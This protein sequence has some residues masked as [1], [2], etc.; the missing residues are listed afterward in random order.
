MPLYLLNMDGEAD[1][2][3]AIERRLKPAIQDLR[4]ISAIDDIGRASLKGATRSIAIAPAPSGEQAFA[5]LLG[6]VGDRKKD[7]F[8]IIIGGDL[9]ARDYK[10]L[11]QGGNAE[12]VIDSGSTEELLAIVRRI[13]TP[14]STNM[15]L[16]VS[17]MPAAGGVGNSTLAIET[18][19]QLAKRK[20]EVGGRVSLIDL[21]FQSSHVCDYLDIEAKFRVKEFMDAPDRLD[22]QLLEVFASRHS[23]GL[24]V[25][26]A[27]RQRLTSRE[28]G[29]DAL[30]ILLER[31]AQHSTCIVV[32][33]P[34]A[35]HV[36]TI[37]VLTASDAVLVT[38]VNTIPGL[39]EISETLAALSSHSE[40]DAEIR[41]VVNRC[42][43]GL[44]GIVNKDHIARV[45]GELERFC[46]RNARIAVDCVNMGKAMS[47][48]HPSDKTVKDIAAISDFCSALRSAAV[49][50]KGSA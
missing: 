19:V 13:G 7:V 33:L 29:V 26:A 20:G 2:L 28:L 10:Q 49:S 38:G 42:Q 43:S 5:R 48:T 32:D 41:A 46:V 15:P 1:V 25:F 22:D 4:R 11:I 50:P 40:I 14:D 44:F 6:I 47:L 36:W 21:D 18:G 17:F 30:S 39:R 8:F 35:D 9:S 34:L 37:P 23:S 12:W 27:P 3:D 16:V 24:T 45:L 31:V